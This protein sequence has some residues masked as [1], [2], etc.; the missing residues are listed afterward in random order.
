MF[1]PDGMPELS[2]MTLDGKADQLDAQIRKLT[3]L[4]N[5]LRHVAQCK[6]ESHMD[7]PKFQR[8]LRVSS[9]S[10]QKAP[11]AASVPEVSGAGFSC[12]PVA[13]LPRS[14]GR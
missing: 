5:A 13:T 8:L 1:G 10:R 3:T 11:K 7:C 12:A 9:T 4:R 14:R 6:A 2:R